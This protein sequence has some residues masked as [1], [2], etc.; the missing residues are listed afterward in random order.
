MNKW[1]LVAPVAGAL[2]VGAGVGTDR[3]L[4]AGE[5]KQDLKPATT[6][7]LTRVVLFNSGVG[8]FSRSGEVDGD[9]RVDLAFPESDINDL[10]KSMVLEDFSKT[11]RVS[12]VS[13]DS[14]EPIA[15]TLSSF[16]VNLTGNPTFAGIVSQMRGERVEVAVSATAAN[17]PG[18]LTGAIV[19]VEHQKV[20]AGAQQVE[21]E[22]LNMWCAEGMRAVK[23]S[24]IQSLRFSNPVVESEF[25]RALDVLALS[26]D[27]Q[28]KAVSLHFAGDG[29]RKVQVGYVV[30][31]PV[32]KT[33]YRL[34]LADKEKP[35]LQGWAMVENP[36]DEDWTGVKMALV[37]GRPISFK[38]DL[39]NPLYV[40]R[41]TVEPELFASLRPPTYAGGYGNA[42]AF[43][44]EV[45]AAREDP[46]TYNPV[47][48]EKEEAGRPRRAV[49]V[50]GLDPTAVAQ[51]STIMGGSG[52]GRAVKPN[53]PNAKF[54]KNAAAELAQRL[55]TGAV[56]N[57]A[58][59]G[60]LGDFYQY[61]IDHPVTLPRQKSAL[62]PIVGKD[63]EGARVSIYNPAVQAKHPLL[64]LR[65]KNTSG[66]HLNQGPI[67]VFEGSVYAGDTRVLDVSPNE[68]R[69]LSY[70]IDL[71]TEVDP[72]A[73]AGAQKITSVKAVK[74]IVTTVTKVTEEK[75]Y[76]IVNRSQTDR[77]LLIEHPNRTSQQFKL[78]EPAKAT[79]DT[80]EV[81]RFQLALKAGET[82]TFTVKEE[83]DNT[84]TVAL[85]NGAED[86]VRYFLSLTEISPALKAKL[87]EALK[88]KG[89]WDAALRELNQV[90]ADLQ[91]LTA[92][93]DR[94]RKNLR[95]T[96][97][98]AEV[99]ATYLKKLSDQEK[100]IDTLTAKQKTLM[101]G[102]FAARKRYEDFLSGIA[103]WRRQGGR[104]TNKRAVIGDGTADIL[105]GG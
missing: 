3:L 77:T 63:I 55:G 61:T 18:K 49:V 26:H 69:L 85:T 42:L 70:A 47:P 94:I 16:A 102:E 24:D 4:T 105:A 82:K 30:E 103:D 43:R 29:R 20:P 73:G 78:I 101:G 48:E 71:G 97:K 51:D 72:K 99:Y 79:E 40:A 66:G 57:A 32:W 54:A 104:A 68:E 58:T 90:N 98:E 35:Y 81:F 22:V 33:S 53:D 15:R 13:Y 96:P 93:Q 2:G 56:G 88:V 74:G 19:G 64:G 87:A 50:R 39:Y 11:G 100:E 62:L 9:A 59:A 92:D 12:A 60:A 10:L 83:R 52:L 91:R 27:S 41:P 65:F 21:V 80:P 75:A 8:Y 86:Q 6:L 14:R 36:T 28:K 44:R 7:P 46:D 95:E 5:A 67:T 31:A 76:K 17:Q 37:S 38:M 89:E 84:A 25:R 45:A 23:M 1:L 34:L